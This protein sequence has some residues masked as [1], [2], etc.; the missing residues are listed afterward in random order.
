MQPQPLSP[1]NR[2]IASSSRSPLRTGELT[3]GEEL[4]EGGLSVDHD[5]WMPARARWEH[6][7]AKAPRQGAQGHGRPRQ[8]ALRG[9]ELP[10]RVGCR[11]SREPRHGPRCER[12]EGGLVASR[13]PPRA[14]SG[15]A[16]RAPRVVPGCHGRTRGSEEVG[17][18]H[19]GRA[20]QK[21]GAASTRRWGAGPRG[22]G[23]A[24]LAAPRR[25][26]RATPG[27]RELAHRP[28]QAE[29]GE[30]AGVGGLGEERWVGGGAR[31]AG[32]GVGGDTRVFGG[33][34][35]WAAGGPGELGHAGGGGGR[36]KRG[37]GPAKGARERLGFFLFIY[38]PLFY[39]SIFFIFP[40][41]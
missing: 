10:R 27:G 3:R 22:G 15:R 31:A 39:I 13:R 20:G 34:A 33:R 24:G 23:G 4:G 35:R 6:S 8:A 14:C 5:G 12:A 9:R 19:A 16:G 41:I 17:A 38:F 18:R 26:K 1:I 2:T 36:R 21:P 7:G 37:C 32:A 28:R 40:L 30:E 11:A 29:H 25:R